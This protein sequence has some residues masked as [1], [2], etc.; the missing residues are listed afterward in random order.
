[1][2]GDD[3]RADLRE[4]VAKAIADYANSFTGGD[5]GDWPYRP[6]DWYGEAD[7]VLAAL[8]GSGPDAGQRAALTDPETC[9]HVG[10]WVQRPKDSQDGKGYTYCPK[11][12][13]KW[14]LY[15]SAG[16]NDR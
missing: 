2:D 13:T 14:P 9:D 10:R 15:P 7:A 11:C 3:G 4:I 1:M 5:G 6:R 12:R 16:G 8:A